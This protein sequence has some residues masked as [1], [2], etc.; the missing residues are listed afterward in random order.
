MSFLWEGDDAFHH[1]RHTD[2]IIVKCHL[3]EKSEKKKNQEYQKIGFLKVILETGNSVVLVF[4]MELL[5]FQVLYNLSKKS[6]S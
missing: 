2:A 6:L 3:S 4:F 1:T 5:S